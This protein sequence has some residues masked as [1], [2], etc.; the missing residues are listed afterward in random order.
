MISLIITRNRR[1]GTY[2]ICR[3]GISIRYCFFSR[4]DR[5]HMYF[6]L[7][8][9]SRHIIKVHKH[10]YE[11]VAK[12]HASRLSSL[13]SCWLQSPGRSRSKEKI[14]KLW[15]KESEFVTVL[16]KIVL[17]LLNVIKKWYTQF[18]TTISRTVSRNKNSDKRTF[19][20][21]KKKLLSRSWR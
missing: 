10:T 19:Y 7:V 20:D 12:K 18:I 5:R 3:R 21:K 14:E 6:S 4:A 8:R 15:G 2:C 9:L 1:D 17:W 11:I 13:R 16:D